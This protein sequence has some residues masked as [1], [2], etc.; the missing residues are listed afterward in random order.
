MLCRTGFDQPRVFQK[1]PGMRP[2]LYFIETFA[3]LGARPSY[4]R[5]VQV[6]DG[7]PRHEYA[8][9]IIFG[10]I[11]RLALFADTNSLDTVRIEMT[12]GIP[13]FANLDREHVAQFLASNFS[14]EAA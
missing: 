7:S 13:R 11:L 12:A 2:L 14:E 5:L 6:F 10:V 8:G 3:L 4:R 1:L 9:A